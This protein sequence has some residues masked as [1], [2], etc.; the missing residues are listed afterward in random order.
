MVTN[1]H[2]ALREFSGTKC[3][4]KVKQNNTSLH[5]ISNMFY[6]PFPSSHHLNPT[7]PCRYH[8]ITSFIHSFVQQM[9]LGT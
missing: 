9:L 1:V 3:Q 8:L 7:F 4:L 6:V 5:A 2:K